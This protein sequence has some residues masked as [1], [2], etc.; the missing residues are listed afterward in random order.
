MINKGNEIK[1]WEMN[2][3]HMCNMTFY[4][5]V[6]REENDTTCSNCKKYEKK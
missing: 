6:K 2:T 4:T 1:G 5:K 3:C